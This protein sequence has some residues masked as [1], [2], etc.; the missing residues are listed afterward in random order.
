MDID[1]VVED[2]T[3]ATEDTALRR[4]YETLQCE[5]DVQHRALEDALRSK[6]HLQQE[7]DTMQAVYEQTK[8][9]KSKLKEQLDTCCQSVDKELKNRNEKFL[10]MEV[11]NK[12]YQETA[13]AAANDRK[14]ALEQMQAALEREKAA[15]ME[16]DHYK[17]LAS[18]LQEQ[19]K[20][21]CVPTSEL[22]LLQQSNVDLHTVSNALTGNSNDLAQMV[23][24]VA[25]HSTWTGSNSS[26]IIFVAVSNAKDGRPRGFECEVARDKSQ[27][28]Q[29][30]ESVLNLTKTCWN[31]LSAWDS[32]GKI[33]PI[34][35]TSYLFEVL[36]TD[37]LFIGPDLVFQ[38]FLDKRANEM[39]WGKVRK[40]KTIKRVKDKNADQNADKN[41]RTVQHFE[42]SED[43][44]T[45]EDD[46]RLRQRKVAGQLPAIEAP[47]EAETQVEG[48]QGSTE[49]L[50]VTTKEP[51]I[52]GDSSEGESHKDGNSS[53]RTKTITFA[54]D[55]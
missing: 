39:G 55:D 7:I 24:D 8:L 2:H 21:L 11:S 4:L 31:D 34:S 25:S 51:F 41:Y 54:P 45:S 33:L 43:E 5:Y 12:N 29:T 3:S 1:S 52:V 20:K 28:V 40:V 42:S 49:L 35:T 38:I 36:M 19:V 18:G 6:A 48:F 26:N 53:F 23:T 14:A 9:E 13:N 16:V 32:R 37:T 10:Q 27:G 30:I 22:Q 17:R 50:G 15:V 46:A 44:S 47:G